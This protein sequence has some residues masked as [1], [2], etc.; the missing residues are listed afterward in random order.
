MQPSSHKTKIVCT[1]GPASDSPEMLSRMMLAGMNIARINFSHGDFSGHGRVIGRIRQAAEAVGRRVA[2]LADL[3]G[4]KIRLGQIA[5][6]PVML[7]PGEPFILTTQEI[8]GSD[9]RAFVSLTSLPQVVKKGDIIFINDGLI[10]LRVEAVQGCE[11]VSRVEVGGELRSRKGVNLPGI[12]LGESAFTKDD[13]SCLKFALENGVDCISQSFVST[14]ADIE[15]V[16][17][18][19][20]VLGYQPFIIAKI[21]RKSGRENIDAIL[22]AA[23]GVMVARGDLGVEIPIEEIAVTQKN[24]IA[25]ANLLGKPVI[26]ATQMLESMVHNRRPT[27]AEA[28]DVAN[29]VLDGT[30]CVMLSGES[31]V[32]QYPLEAVAML[33]KIAAAT[34]PYR[35]PGHYY[36]MLNYL[37]AAE[38]KKLVD[39]ITSSVEKISNEIAPGAVLVPS[40]SGATARSMSR[41]RLPFW[42]FAISSREQTCQELI[43]SYGVY[44]LFYD[45]H[46]DD[47][48]AYAR[49]LVKEYAIE[50]D[51]VIMTEGPSPIRPQANHS[52]EIIDLCRPL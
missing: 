7:R 27:R 45:E 20:A 34:E 39:L 44:P 50:G 42:I 17:E 15:A 32:G 22:A 5:G 3:P 16:R 25:K 9:R 40:L 4:P 43:F 24:I 49:T 2:I 26:T 21:E 29:A 46:P 1:I 23:D 52:M 30:D 47:W 51:Y 36:R 6:E 37:K 31:A 11:V 8:E 38:S 19:A 12:D 35:S 10:Q 48:S 14:A 13:Y 28:T 41:F 33:A 18:A